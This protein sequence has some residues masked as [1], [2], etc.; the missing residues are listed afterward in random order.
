MFFQC[1]STP[2]KIQYVSPNSKVTLN[3]ENNLL[4]KSQMS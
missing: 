2:K 4:A 1:L 3:Y